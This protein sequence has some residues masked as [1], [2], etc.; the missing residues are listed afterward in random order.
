LAHDLNQLVGQDPKKVKPEQIFYD[1]Q[2]FQGVQFSEKTQAL[3]AADAQN[4]NSARLNRL[5]LVDAYPGV[6]AYQDGVLGISNA[7][8]AMLLS[9]G[10][11]CFLVGRFTG[12]WLLK[13]FS[14]H[15]SLGVYGVVNV[16]VCF[17]VF[18]KLGWIS[19][20]CVFLSFFFMSIMYPTIFALGIFGLG[21]RAKMASAFIVMAIM[22]GAAL[23]KFMGF[24][25]DQHDMSYGFIVPVVC[26]VV[27]ALY[28][29]CW[30]MLSNAKSMHN[31]SI[32]SGH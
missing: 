16:I 13:K 18:S 23:P 15:K 4:K 19:V 2:R 27:V 31:E 12:A 8:A 1:P 28:G 25:A 26:F 30:P 21:A 14:A 22:G 9:F 24:V 5:L 32:A 10:F 17:L 3:L 6:I 7:G 29:F 11:T 20:V